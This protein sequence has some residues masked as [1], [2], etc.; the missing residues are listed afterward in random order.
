ALRYEVARELAESLER[1]QRVECRVDAVQG[2]FPSMTRFGMAAL[3][4]H[5][6]ITVDAG[7][8]AVLVDG[9]PTATTEQRQAALRARLPKSVALRAE[10]VLAMKSVEQKE[11][12]R[13][14]EVD[15][16]PWTPPARRLHRHVFRWCEQASATSA[17]WC[18]S[19]P[20][21]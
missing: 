1:G 19:P 16:P 21:R 2:T 11:L 15:L 7:G 18:A 17:D 9:L 3:L 12:A 4:P 20:T 6:T 14:A 10:K 13:D 5:R 8:G